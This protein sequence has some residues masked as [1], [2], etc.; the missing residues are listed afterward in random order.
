MAGELL[1]RIVVIVG[2]MVP[3]MVLAFLLFRL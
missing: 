2:G 1:F 3:V